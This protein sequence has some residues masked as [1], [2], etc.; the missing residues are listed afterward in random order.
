VGLWRSFFDSV[1]IE[2]NCF[3][4]QNMRRKDLDSLSAIR[5]SRNL[6]KMMAQ[7]RMEKKRRMRRTTF[8]TGPE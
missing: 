6:E 7:E 4:S 5:I 8:T 2:A 1:K 3:P